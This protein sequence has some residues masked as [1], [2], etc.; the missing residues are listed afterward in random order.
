MDL[1]I[2]T[3]DKEDLVKA[4]HIFINNAIYEYSLTALIFTKSPFKLKTIF[5]AP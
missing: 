2:R 5:F 4:D 3:Q 1:W